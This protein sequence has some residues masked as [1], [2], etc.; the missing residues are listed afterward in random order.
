MHRLLVCLA[1]LLITPLRG[2]GQRLADPAVI[3]SQSKERLLADLERLP[4]YTCVQTITR[5]Y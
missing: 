1:I 4:R 2:P 3:F 5:R